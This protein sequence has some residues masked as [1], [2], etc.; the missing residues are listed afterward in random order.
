[1]PSAVYRLRFKGPGGE[2]KVGKEERRRW[3]GEEDIKKG[4][5]KIYYKQDHVDFIFSPRIQKGTKKCFVRYLEESLAP[6]PNVC[7][8][9]AEN[10]QDNEPI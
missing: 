6:I 7:A 4:K 3:R 10:T 8:C 9:K 2:G 5:G 1:M